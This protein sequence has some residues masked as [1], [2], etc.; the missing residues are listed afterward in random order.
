MKKKIIGIFV[1]MLMVLTS[2]G[3]ASALSTTENNISSLDAEIAILKPY[4]G[5]YIFNMKVAPLPAQGRFRAIVIGMVDVEVDVIN[6]AIDTVE[7]YVDGQLKETITQEPYTWT[8]NEPMVV[9]PIHTLK[10]VGYDGETE[11][12]NE[13]ISVLYIN[14]FSRP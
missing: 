8:W 10:V 6:P 11:I 2:L 3:V 14:P 12:G 13:E 4:A 7:F 5:V 1:C 9:P